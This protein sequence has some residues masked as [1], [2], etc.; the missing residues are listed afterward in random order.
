MDTYWYSNIHQKILFFTLFILFG[1]RCK[2]LVLYDHLS[3][4]PH[5]TESTEFSI[6]HTLIN[7]LKFNY[8]FYITI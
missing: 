1:I 2:Y 3:S 7:R 6:F 8:K 5:T 4:G